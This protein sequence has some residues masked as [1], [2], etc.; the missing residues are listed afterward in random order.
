M[1]IPG[2]SK[3]TKI[4][5]TSVTLAGNSELEP[6]SESWRMQIWLKYHKMCGFSHGLAQSEVLGSGIFLGL[7]L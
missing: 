7:H 5:S 6:L 2:F 3:G 4:P 1:A